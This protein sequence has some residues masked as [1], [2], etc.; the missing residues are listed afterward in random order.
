MSG[1][2]GEHVLTCLDFVVVLML[3]FVL[4][5]VYYKRGRC[6][7]REVFVNLNLKINKNHATTIMYLC[8]NLR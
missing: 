8:D 3:T 7:C 1:T 2:S 6:E 5:C 4:G